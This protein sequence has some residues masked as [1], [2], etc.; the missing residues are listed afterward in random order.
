MIFRKLGRLFLMAFGAV[1]IGGLAERL[2]AVVT[3][4]AMLILAVGVLGHLQIF[5]F[6]LE[7]LGVT[8]GAFGLVLVHMG[9]VAEKYGSGAPLGFK[10][11]IPAAGLFLL[12]IGDAERRKGQ[13]ADADPED[14]PGAFSQAFTSLLCRRPAICRPTP[15]ILFKVKFI[16]LQK[17]PSREK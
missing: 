15:A 6:H 16:S 11:D 8:V 12:R 4:A 10:L 2:L 7:D 17:G 9:F 1:G 3:D 13:D 5:F 14:S